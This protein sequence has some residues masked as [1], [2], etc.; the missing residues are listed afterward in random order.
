MFKRY[1]LT[2]SLPSRNYIEKAIEAS[3]VY[4]EYGSGGSTHLAAE[5]GKLT[6]SVESDIRWLMTLC[7]S[8]A[9]QGILKNIIPLWA[10]IG[11]THHWG[12]PLTR[13]SVDQWENYPKIAWE[14]CYEHGHNPDTILIDGRFRTACLLTSLTHLSKPAKI[15]FDDYAGR[16]H[17]HSV[18]SVIKP[19]EIID[20]RMAVFEV[21]PDSIDKQ[22]VMEELRKPLDTR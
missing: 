14:Y 17:Y 12:Y 18:E 19:V 22:Q 10:D 8:A 3:H 9:E 21:E 6:I 5:L 15:I 7:S 11:E 13:D 1:P 16:D 4:L 2:F 20:E